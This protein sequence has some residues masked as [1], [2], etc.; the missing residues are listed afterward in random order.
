M[1]I[2]FHGN[3]QLWAIGEFL[4]LSPA[5]NTMNISVI[6]G[7]QLV[8]G[9]QSHEEEL[10]AVES[11]D[12]IFT[13]KVGGELPWPSDVN[14]KQGVEIIPMSV[15]YN[16][17]YF[18]NYTTDWTPVLDYAKENKIEKA[19]KFAVNE[20]DLGYAARFEENK[21]RMIQKEQD[22]GIEADMRVSQFIEGGTRERLLI[23]MNHPTSIVF[24]HWTNKVLE[25]IGKAKLGD[26]VLKLC[27]ENEN[28][29]NLPCFDGVCTAAKKR[30]GLSW[31]GTA[32]DNEVAEYYIRKALETK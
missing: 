26:K 30:L 19:V 13:H 7:H 14:P 8:L 12:I 23:T 21:A 24:F 1:N 17:G 11:A 3:C 9:E 29:V 5:A 22:E 20:A 32:R 15:F 18:I 31:G 27:G 2:C 25:R 28:I 6:Q 16:S 10:K 4:K